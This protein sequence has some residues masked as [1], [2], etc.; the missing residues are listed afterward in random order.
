MI[1]LVLKDLEILLKMRMLYRRFVEQGRQ[2]LV[3][4]LIKVCLFNTQTALFKDCIVP[5][6]S[7]KLAG[8]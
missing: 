5:L 6:A 2:K 8:K 7:A 1:T 4:T 3:K